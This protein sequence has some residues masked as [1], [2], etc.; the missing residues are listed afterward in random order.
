[1]SRRP[2]ATRQG[3]SGQLRLGLALAALAACALALLLTQ[4]GAAASQAARDPRALAT[5]GSSSSSKRRASG[6]FSSNNAVKASQRHSALWTS[7]QHEG[8]NLLQDNGGQPGPQVR[9]H[10]PMFWAVSTS[11][12]P[13]GNS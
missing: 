6:V 9:Y 12:P 2:T 10:M 11:S 3:Y 8:R 4:H 13:G 5:G 1:M 7:Q